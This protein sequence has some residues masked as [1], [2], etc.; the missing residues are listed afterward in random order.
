MLE[1]PT[2]K[3]QLLREM[4]QLVRTPELCFKDAE[5]AMF[6]SPIPKHV[7]SDGVAD[8]S[9]SSEC[10]FEDDDIQVSQDS[11]DNDDFD[12]ILEAV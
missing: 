5:E 10:E 7:R 2:A 1:D 4:T 8:E 6:G 11:N 9:M 12:N 3:A